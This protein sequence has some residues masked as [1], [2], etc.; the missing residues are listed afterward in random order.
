MNE[1]FR[2]SSYVYWISSAAAPLQSPGK[3]GAG[4]E[5]IP[6]LQVLQQNLY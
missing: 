3:A 5:K 6:L 2:A 4:V 1:H